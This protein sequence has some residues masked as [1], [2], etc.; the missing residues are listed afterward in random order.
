MK[1]TVTTPEPVE[2]PPAEIELKIDRSELI[3]LWN[4]VNVASKLE[5]GR[6]NK[7]HGVDKVTALWDELDKARRELNIGYDELEG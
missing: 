4:I 6:F 7:Q 3:Y 1:A 2:Q 5:E